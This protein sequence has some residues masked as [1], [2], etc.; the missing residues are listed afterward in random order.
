MIRDFF[1]SNNYKL[2][3]NNQHPFETE[4]VPPNRFQ[5]APYNSNSESILENKRRQSKK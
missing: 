3:D 5:V 1:R 4:A 2:L